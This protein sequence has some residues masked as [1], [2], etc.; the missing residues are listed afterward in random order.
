AIYWNDALYWLKTK[1]R[2]FTYYRLDIEDDEHLIITTIQ[3][4]QRV[5]N[6]LQSYGYMD[7]MQILMQIPHLLHQEGKFFQSCGCL[8]L[9]CRDDIGSSEFNIYEMTKGCF[10]WSVRYRVDTDDF[11]TLLPEGWSIRSTVWSIVLG[12]REDDSLLVINLSGKV[13]QYNLI[14]KTLYDI[15]DRGSNQL[16]DNHDNDDELLQQLE[17]EH[18]IYEFIRSFAR[19]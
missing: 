18:N 2:K 9:V 15:F 5:L 6:F 8:L 19:V 7:P 14:S 3:I 1:N 12:E 16:D 17:A 4:P 10:V 13:I 11:I